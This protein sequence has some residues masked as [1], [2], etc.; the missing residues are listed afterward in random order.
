MCSRPVTFG[1]GIDIVNGSP[2]ASSEGAKKP[3]CSHL[4]AVKAVSRWLQAV[5]ADNQVCLTKHTAALLCWLHQNFWAA[6]ASEAPAAGAGLRLHV[7]AFSGQRDAATMQD[8]GTA[9]PSNHLARQPCL[10][11]WEW[12]CCTCHALL[13]HMAWSSI[14]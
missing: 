8:D 13:P 11:L 4:A 1:G 10:L 12:C 7:T 2:V 3:C 6:L 9:V 5:A 14:A